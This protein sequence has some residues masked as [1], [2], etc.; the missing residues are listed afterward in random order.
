MPHSQPPALEYR[1][2]TIAYGARTAVR[3][4][5]FAV[6]PGEVLAIVGASGSG[7]STLLRAAPGLLDAGGRV[8]GGSIRLAGQELTSL[9]HR[10]LRAVRGAGVGLLFQDP[11]AALC[12]VRRVG[13]QVR[14]TLAAHGVRDRAEARR[15]A[16]DL[17]ARLDLPDG[18]RL[19][20]AYPFELSGGMQQRVGIA[21]ALLLRPA[22]LLADEPTSALD[23]LARRRVLA[24]LARLA[25]QD[26]AALVVVTHDLGVARRIAGQV[27]VLQDGAVAEQGPAAQVL[28][29]PRT[30][31][32]RALLDAVPRL[33][34]APNREELTP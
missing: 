13:A 8:T 18:E 17:F 31:C 30:A 4:V 7:K 22:V 33:Q 10:A 3:D 2:V 27:L 6:Q 1:A 24:E 14:E 32:T 34:R 11:A 5:S 20:R 28:D 25:A 12:P 29:H 23:T 19:W 9:G 21:L 16:L 15:R 26:G